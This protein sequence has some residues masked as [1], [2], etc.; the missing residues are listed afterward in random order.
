MVGGAT[1]VSVGWGN[2]VINSECDKGTLVGFVTLRGWKSIHARIIGITPIAHNLEI[3]N[4]R[5]DWRERIF[6]I[7]ASNLFAPWQ[8]TKPFAQ[9]DVFVGIIL[10]SRIIFGIVCF[11]KAW[12]MNKSHAISYWIS[13]V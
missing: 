3:I 7:A 13:D 4:L 11:I 9:Y 6:F 5:T 10:A 12:R 2:I 1:T 8:P